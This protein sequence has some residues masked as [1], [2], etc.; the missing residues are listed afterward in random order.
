MRRVTVWVC[1]CFMVLLWLYACGGDGA[2]MSGQNLIGSAASWR[3]SIIDSVG[4]VGV[5]SSIATDSNNKVH[6]SYYDITNQAMK[7]ATNTSG[8]WVTSI[9]ASSVYGGGSFS[10]TTIKI[11]SNNKIHIGYYDYNNGIQYMTNKTGSWEKTTISSGYG[12]YYGDMALGKNNEVN[13]GYNTTSGLQL[14]TNATGT[15]VTSTVTTSGK[16]PPIFPSVGLAVDKNNKLHIV[17][18][19]WDGTHVYLGYANNITGSWVVSTID[20]T[21]SDYNGVR[22]AVDSNINIHATYGTDSTIGN[23]KYISNVS[24]GWVAESIGDKGDNWSATS[25]TVDTNDKVHVCAIGGDPRVQYITNAS[26]V[27]TTSNIADAQWSITLAL[28][29]D[30][31]AHIAYYVVP[32]GGPLMYA[33]NAN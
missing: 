16:F 11:D 20:N 7:Y 1:T 33:T 6:V 24:G 13:I 23:L 17:Y 26:G 29:S 28:D 10:Q 31:K 22:V 27:W 12:L 4:D 19:G 2:N 3:T 5:G 21:R 30:N 32:F 25:I 9:I 18:G 8:S 15:W 14:T